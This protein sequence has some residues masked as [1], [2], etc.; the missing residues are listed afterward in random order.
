MQ[1]AVGP[2]VIGGGPGGRFVD[3]WIGAEARRGGGPK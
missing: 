2:A 1:D 3:E